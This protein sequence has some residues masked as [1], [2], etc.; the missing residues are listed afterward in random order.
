[1]L[2]WGS[3]ELSAAGS[4]RVRHYTFT[5][6]DNWWSIAGCKWISTITPSSPS[7]TFPMRALLGEDRSL[8]YTS[9]RPGWYRIYLTEIGESKIRKIMNVPNL[10]GSDRRA[11]AYLVQPCNVA[12]GHSFCVALKRS[13]FWHITTL[14]SPV[15]V[16]HVAMYMAMY[17]LALNKKYAK[18][19]FTPI[20]HSSIEMTIF[21]SYRSDC[22]CHAFFSFDHKYLWTPLAIQLVQI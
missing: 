11:R 20:A 2:P 7:Y 6:L 3:V 8:R 10:R 17:R 16:I 18:L 19:L 12:L 5:L 9:D 15:V 22:S 4:P 1:M 21:W 13:T 14:V